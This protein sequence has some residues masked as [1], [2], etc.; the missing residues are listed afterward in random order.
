MYQRFTVDKFLL[1]QASNE[2]V[3]TFDQD[4]DEDSVDNRSIYILK[5]ESKA[6]QLLTNVPIDQYDIDGQIV[7]LKYSALE[8]NVT[9]EIHVTDKVQSILD[10]PL[11]VEFVKQFVLESS[12]DS[13]VAILSP[14][15]HEA[16]SP[17]SVKLEE[18]A[19]KSKK[20]FNKFQLQIASDV[21]FLDIIFETEMADAAKADFDDLK[22][23]KQYFLRARATDGKESGNWSAPV[24]FTKAKKVV[25]SPTGADEPP[26]KKCDDFFGGVISDMELVGSP[27]NGKTPNSFLF[28]FDA[29][30]DEESLRHSDIIVTMREV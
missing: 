6:H 17:L 15:D 28:E 23:A 12:V 1:R 26:A 5:D 30:L 22:D 4:I 10:E 29:D 13:S 14:A 21:N 8:F 9:Y 3:L 11:E 2:I 27:E 16:V 18:T 20:L 25:P 7:T 24:T 19:G